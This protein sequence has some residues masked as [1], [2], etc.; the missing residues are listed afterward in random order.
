M[1]LPKQSRRS[2]HGLTLLEVIAAVALL[3][4]SLVGI[5]LSFSKNQEKTMLAEKRLQAIRL[6]DKFFFEKEASQL[7]LRDGDSGTFL[8]NPN[9][10]WQVAKTKTLPKLGLDVFEFRVVDAELGS[11]TLLSVEFFAPL[12]GKQ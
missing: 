8:S 7:Q 6:A 9:V 4:T 1:K 3:S 12:G 5:L 10:S 2:H 11:K